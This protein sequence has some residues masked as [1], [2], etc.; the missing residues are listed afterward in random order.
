MTLLEAYTRA[1]WDASIGYRDGT[2][3]NEITVGFFT[4]QALE[5]RFPRI[6]KLCEE[7]VNMRGFV[8]FIEDVK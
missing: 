1:Y 8:D 7:R 5:C 6:R 2:L 4:R 3:S